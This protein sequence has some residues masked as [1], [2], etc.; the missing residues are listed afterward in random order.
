MFSVKKRSN[1]DCEYSKIEYWSNDLSIMNIK[2]LKNRIAR[3]NYSNWKCV[4]ASLPI[5]WF[6][7]S[8]FE[9][10]GTEKS[11]PTVKLFETFFFPPSLFMFYYSK[12][13]SSFQTLGFI[14]IIQMLKIMMET[15]LSKFHLSLTERHDE[16]A[17][18]QDS[19]DFISLG[20]FL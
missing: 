11:N 6:D 1:D 19:K 13:S 10:Q 16:S 4:V 8:M 17:R 9:C 20:N 14:L 3:S 5:K 15:L 12:F 2:G 18:I 7:V